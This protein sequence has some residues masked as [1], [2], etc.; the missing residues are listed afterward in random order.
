MSLFLFAETKNGY[1]SQ[2]S[3]DIC[4]CIACKVIR[5][6]RSKH[7]SRVWNLPSLICINWMC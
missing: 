3:P 4:L 5:Y 7:W 2:K 6:S 1:T